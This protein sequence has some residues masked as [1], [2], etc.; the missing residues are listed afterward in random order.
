[1]AHLR[2]LERLSL[3]LSARETESPGLRVVLPVEETNYGRT[4]TTSEY[5]HWHHICQVIQ[6]FTCLGERR[7]D[8]SPWCRQ[9]GTSGKKKDNWKPYFTVW[10]MWAS[11]IE[12]WIFVSRKSSRVVAAASAAARSE[13][14][15]INNLPAWNGDHTWVLWLLRRAYTENTSSNKSRVKPNSNV[16]EMTVLWFGELNITTTMKDI[17]WN[18]LYLIT[19]TSVNLALFQIL[20]PT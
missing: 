6:K 12:D 20:D 1:M 5:L 19:S 18:Q 16:L 8:P 17:P 10:K 15:S 9:Q 3:I 7:W 2:Y 13:F 11:K 14:L 4:S